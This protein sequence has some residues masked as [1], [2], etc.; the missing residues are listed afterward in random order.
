MK[1]IELNG[2]HSCDGS[3]NCSDIDYQRKLSVP[4]VSVKSMFFPRQKPA[5]HL[6]D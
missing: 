3:K 2:W 4:Y 5:Q 6:S 1:T